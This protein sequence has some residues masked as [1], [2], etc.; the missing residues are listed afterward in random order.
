[1]LAA[2]K[3]RWYTN[4]AGSWGRLTKGGF[5]SSES[6]PAS[7][8]KA[9]NTHTHMHTHTD[10]YPRIPT[11]ALTLVH[12]H[13]HTRTCAQTHTHTRTHLLLSRLQAQLAA[14]CP[15]LLELDEVHDTGGVVAAPRRLWGQTGSTTVSEG[16]STCRQSTRVQAAA[17]LPPHL[18]LQPHPPPAHPYARTLP[19]LPQLVQA[20]KRDEHDVECGAEGLRRQWGG[21]PT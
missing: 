1:V 17:P 8:R 20:L 3:G 11:L 13:P 9:N 18:P 15:A 19:Y 7:E 21:C 10:T 12:A 5:R 4:V 14:L 2:E 16:A 6:D